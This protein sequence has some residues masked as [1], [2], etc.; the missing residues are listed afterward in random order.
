MHLCCVIEL[1]LSPAFLGGYLRDT[2]GNVRFRFSVGKATLSILAMRLGTSGNSD[3]IQGAGCFGLKSWCTMHFLLQTK[4]L[5][6]L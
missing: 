4:F 3:S 1:G 5:L 2:R 6:H